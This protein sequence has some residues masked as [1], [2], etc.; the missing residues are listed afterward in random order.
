[1]FEIYMQL[2]V[3]QSESSFTLEIQVRML[4]CK[5]M[6]GNVVMATLSSYF[7]RSLSGGRIKQAQY[8]M[9]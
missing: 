3:F 6:I 8:I 5:E 2:L 1:M 4:L 7:Q 9:A